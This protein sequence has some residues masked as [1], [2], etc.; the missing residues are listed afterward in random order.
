M[1]HKIIK[2]V[3]YDKIARKRWDNVAPFLA[4]TITGWVY[5]LNI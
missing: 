2:R 1:Q 3:D 4:N 5:V